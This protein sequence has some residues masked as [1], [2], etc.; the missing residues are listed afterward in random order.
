MRWK[1]RRPALASRTSNHHSPLTR[2][3]L[4]TRNNEH[5]FILWGH[6]HSDDI[7]HT[8]MIIYSKGQ[9]VWH[10]TA[11]ITTD[12]HTSDPRHAVGHGRCVCVWAG[13]AACTRN[14]MSHSVNLT[15]AD[16]IN[17]L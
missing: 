8:E 1:T 5:T 12:T 10:E 6:A 15:D 4:F 9:H 17:R 11:R 7:H 2:F 16:V 13:G 3:H 14:H